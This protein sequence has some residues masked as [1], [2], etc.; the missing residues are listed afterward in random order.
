MVIPQ[1]GL[2]KLSLYSRFLTCKCA[3]TL[4]IAHS[5]SSP[6]EGGKSRWGGGGGGVLIDG[7]GP[8][9]EHNDRGDDR[10]GEGYG[11]G[12]GYGGWGTPGLPG[13]VILDFLPDDDDE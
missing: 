2:K 9:R 3:E 12:G 6:G 10:Q 1:H 5:I 8:Q 7:Q 4:T 11:G 13:A